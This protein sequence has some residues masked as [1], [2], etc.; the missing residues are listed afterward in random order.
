MTCI[1]EGPCICHKQCSHSDGPRRWAWHNTHITRRIAE[2]QRLTIR[3]K[4]GRTRKRPARPRTSIKDKI[5]NLH[6]LLRVPSFSRWPL[7]VRFFCEDV[8]RVWQLWNERVAGSVRGG[9]NVL[10]DLK[11]P[12]EVINDDGLLMSTQA[13]AKQKREALGKGGIQ[14]L[15][16]GYSE[17]KD[18]VDK[19]IFLLAED[20]G[21]KCAV[22]AKNLGPQTAMALVCPRENCRTASHMTCLATKF[23]EDEGAGAAVTPVSGRCPGCREELRWIDLIKE[24]SLRVR[25]E[26][27]VAQMMKKPKER[28]VKKPMAKEGTASQL[29][30]HT[31]VKEDGADP[32]EDLADADMRALNASDESLPDDWQ[33]QD[34]DDDDRMSVMSGHSALSDGMSPTKRSSTTSKLPAVIEDSDWDDAELLD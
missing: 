28:K 33:Y 17:L 25:G 22:C 30:A 21:L 27:E 4:T 23:V 6:L 11:L 32:N 24:L 3:P 15:D 7:Q 13:K 29:E 31:L 9:V 19:S 12:E 26:K 34:D 10:L 16:I 18:H 1:I 8:Y 5:S 2:E 20:E 14:G